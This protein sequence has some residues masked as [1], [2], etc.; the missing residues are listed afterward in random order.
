MLRKYNRFR[1]L[2]VFFR[3]PTTDLQLRQ[4]SRLC[5]IAPPSVKRYLR[6]FI[7][8]GFVRET[9]GGIYK[10]YRANRESERFKQ[11]KRYTLALRLEGLVEHIADN[12]FPDAIVL[13]G[14]A[15]WGEDIESSDIYIAVLAQER[16][17]DVGEYEKALNRQ[18][19]VMFYP[20]FRNLNPDLKSDIL[21]G[22]VLYGYIDAYPRRE[23]LK[24]KEHSISD[25]PGLHHPE[26]YQ[27]ATQLHHRGI[28]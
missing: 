9:H 3:F 17:L 11:L 25:V 1:V 26:E 28:L 21:N 13:F 12:C 6:E 18:I 2:E 24:A 20:S 8:E 14:S 23:E 10:A 19:S 15:R 16:E 22:I 4:I 5:G 7:D 27:R